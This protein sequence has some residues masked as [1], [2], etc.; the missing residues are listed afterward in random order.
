MEKG[1]VTPAEATTSNMLSVIEACE[2]INVGRS[3]L[4]KWEHDGIITPYRTTGGHRRYIKEEL[5][6]INK[7]PRYLRM[8]T[9]GYCRVSSSEQKEELNK[10]IQITTEYCKEH[11]YPYKIINDIGSGTNFRRKGFTELVKM[12]CN[13]GCNRII[14]CYND[15]LVR[16]GFE[17]L[18][19]VCEQN[20]VELVVL[21]PEEEIPCK[22]EMV[23]DAISTIYSFAKK[24]YKTNQY[25]HIVEENKKMFVD[26]KRKRIRKK[27]A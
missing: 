21:N 6:Q 20:N 26:E 14:V 22:K 2:L 1:I 12:I 4:Y 11:D 23:D 18:K 3:T 8:F 9:V 10:Q 19:V 24:L 17:M 15:T 13:G 7:R 5:L 25:K 27:T 16:F